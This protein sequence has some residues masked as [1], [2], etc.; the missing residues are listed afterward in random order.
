MYF[1]LLLKRL[2]YRFIH[3]DSELLGYCAFPIALHAKPL[4]TETASAHRSLEPSATFL[5][6][7]IISRK[8]IDKA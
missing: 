7:K 2:E 1:F 6:T 8:F 3:E 4:P 5:E